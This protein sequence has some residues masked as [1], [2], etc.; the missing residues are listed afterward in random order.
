MEAAVSTNTT[1]EPLSIVEQ[2]KSYAD[3]NK[4]SISVLAKEIGLGRSTIS[5]YVNGAYGSD[6]ANIDKRVA[7]FLSKHTG[8]IINL[9]PPQRLKLHRSRASTKAAMQRLCSAYAKAVR[10]MLLWVS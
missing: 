6:T 9:Q 5:K 10:S 2:L 8:N 7:Q 1:T 4:I 3:S